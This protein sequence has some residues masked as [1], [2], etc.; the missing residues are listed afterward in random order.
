M[1]Y[2]LSKKYEKIGA[3][4]GSLENSV[5][6]LLKY[7]EKGRLAYI[8]FNG[9][10]LYSD[11]VTID[12]VYKEVTGKT[13]VEFEK[14]QEGY[15]E[16]IKRRDREHKTQIPKLTEYWRRK[17]RETLSEDKWKYWD[18]IVPIRLGDLYKGMELENCLEITSLLN[19]GGTLDEAR[20]LF[21]D[22]GHSGMSG[23]LVC[24]MV[25]EFCD[26]GKVFSDYVQGDK[27]KY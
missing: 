12:S 18:E 26:R 7:R 15:I 5:N 25:E 24:S 16:D 20:D 9:T 21:Y 19:D 3:E 4:W 8:N 1:V 10:K 14:L 2:E 22:Q 23:S 6:K 11:T 17:G 27:N 13:K